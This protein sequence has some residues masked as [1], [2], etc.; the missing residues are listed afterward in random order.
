MPW[1]ADPLPP[2]QIETLRRWIDEGARW[3]DGVT[4]AVVAAAPAPVARPAAPP[5]GARAGGP[6]LVFNRDVRPILSDNCYHLPRTRSE[7]PAGRAAPRPRRGGQVTPPLGQRRDRS[8]EPREERPGPAHHEPRRA[9]ADAPRLER[10]GAAERG[11]DRH[12]PPLDRR[13]GASGSPTGRTSRRLAPR[14]RAV[15]RAGLAEE[16]RGRLRP[17]RDRE[18]TAS[19]RRPRPRPPSC[20][21]ALSLDLTG[22]PPTPEE[23]RAFLSDSA[24]GAYERQVD[25]LLASPRFGERMAS[26]WLDL[27][28]YADS[29]GY[30]SDNA[31]HGLALPRLR[32]RRLQPEPALRPLHHGAA[33]RRPAARTR[34][35]SRR[36]P[37]ATTGCSRPPRRAEPSPRSTAPCTWRIARGM[38]R[39]SGSARRSAAPSA[40]TTSSTRSSPRTSTASAPS[41][42][43]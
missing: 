24:A 43:T 12:P 21:A 31:A 11:P 13:R 4:V 39:R 42:P 14:F 41:S 19:P 7:P 28:R 26:Y 23:V 5:S 29:V 18:G 6:R 30:H 10:Q 25:R 34:R 37:R 36:S 35:R 40:T 22:L 2:A 17:G 20:C 16:P 15:Q 33:R 27:V 3:P 9:E 32:H 1:L 8:R 38:P